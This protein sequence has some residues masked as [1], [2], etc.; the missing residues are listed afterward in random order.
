MPTPVPASDLPAN[1]VP[2]S[3]LPTSTLSRPTL[4]QRY[5]RARMNVPLPERWVTPR[6]IGQ[7]AGFVASP[8]GGIPMIAASMVGGAI[9]DPNDRL[10]GAEVEGVK[11]LG[12]LAGTKVLGKG[13]ELIG[14]Y[15]GKSGMLERTA[16]RI[17]EGV[18]SLYQ[19]YILGSV[20]KTAEE[21]EQQLGG[22]EV[23]RVVGQRLDNFRN[24]LKTQFAGRQVRVFDVDDSGRHMSSEVMSIDDA[25]DHTRRLFA[26]SRG[27]T[28]V[29]KNIAAGP[30]TLDAAQL[31][32]KSLVQ[33]LN[34]WSPGVGDQYERFSADYGLSRQ[35]EKVFAGSKRTANIA[36]KPTGVVDQPKLLE[37]ASKAEARINEIRPGAG[38]T[39]K[40][41]ISPTGAKAVKETEWG[42]RI[43]GGEYGI[44]AI[45]HPPKPYMPETRDILPA[46]TGWL[47][48]PRIAP[49]VAALG[50]T[51]A[52][53]WLGD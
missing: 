24:S 7:M 38:T 44:S 42:E 22:G 11:A 27:T 18:G 16:Q 53:E 5:E 12:A 32:K 1:A 29:Q 26:A 39:L 50:L 23:T 45:L 14:R 17:G 48:D 49:L 35:L 34:Q 36:G 52:E 9:E 20:P 31:S 46:G 28:G 15:A 13:L 8:F 25:I 47:N 6:T 10:T 2:M 43:H 4:E 3:D 33:T 19:R 40:K 30:L 41:A 51:T 37:R 21:L